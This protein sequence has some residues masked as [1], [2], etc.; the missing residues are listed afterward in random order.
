VDGLEPG[1]LAALHFLMWTE[2]ALRLARRLDIGSIYASTHSYSLNRLGTLLADAGI[3][4]WHVAWHG[5]HPRADVTL[6]LQ[7]P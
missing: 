7:K 2:S 5:E 4:D 1:G 3:R 6:F